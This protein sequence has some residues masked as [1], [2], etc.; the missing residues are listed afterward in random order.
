M[1]ISLLSSSYFDRANFNNFGY[2]VDWANIYC[3]GTNSCPK[4][5]SQSIRS[6]DLVLI[7]EPNLFKQQLALSIANCSKKPV[8]SANHAAISVLHDQDLMFR[9]L[10]AGNDHSSRLLMKKK[11]A[12]NE[13]PK[14]SDNKYGYFISCNEDGKKIPE[15]VR[16][17]PG[18]DNINAK[19]ASEVNSSFS[20]YAPSKQHSLFISP[21]FGDDQICLFYTP[22][23]EIN[24]IGIT[25]FKDY[26]SLDQ[27]TAE[28]A[29]HF[30]APIANKIEV[31]D[32]N[33][34]VLRIYLSKDDLGDFQLVNARCDF[35]PLNDPEFN[36][37]VDQSG[38]T[39][40][41]FMKSVIEN[42]D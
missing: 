34:E 31:L 25:N 24:P 38:M 33:I 19:I 42:Y 1:K 29:I 16:L 37:A 13:A 28:E 3:E 6:S 12:R 35:P 15:L 30:A 39:I 26:F 41:D 10:G 11:F 4:K 27:T 17:A 14:L 21:K 40:K 8:I 5:I 2:K 36:F 22:R 20:R 7:I 23:G 9:Y 32:S 18:E